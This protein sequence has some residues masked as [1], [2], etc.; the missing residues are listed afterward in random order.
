MGARLGALSTY[1]EQALPVLASL[2][3]LS[4][5]VLIQP[6]SAQS[7]P[8]A[9]EPSGSQ[10]NQRP[11]Q[12]LRPESRWFSP[13][14][15]VRS[16]GPAIAPPEYIVNEPGDYLNPYRQHPL[17][18]DFPLFG[19]E[20][21]F[22]SVTA[23]ERLIVEQRNVPTPTLITG[24]GPVRPGFFGNGRQRVLNSDLSVTFD[25]F[26]GQQA[27]KPVDWR[28]KFTPVWNVNYL[29]V[30]E[31]GVV[32][33][34]TNKGK[35]RTTQD[36]SLQEAFVEYHIGDLSDR[37]DFFSIE[38][39]ILPFRSDFR[40]FIF[41]DVNLGVR[42]FGNYDQNKWQYNL[43]VFDTL[44][45]NSNSLLNE[46]KDREQFVAIANIYRQDWPVLGYTSS[47]S[48][49]YNKDER[50]GLDFDNNGFL[51][52]PAPIGTFTNN[53]IEAYYLGWA[54]EG[55]FGRW[56]I[57]HAIYQVFG[58]ETANALAGRSVDI[59]AQFA[60]V[61][62]SYD[63]DWW[64]PRVFGLYASGDNDTRD[65]DANGFDAIF[66][67]PNFAGGDFSF[68][69]R[70]GLRL[71][72]T[73]LTNPQSPLVDLQTSK[74]EGQSNFVNPGVILLGGAADFEWTPKFRMQA[75]ASYL[76][77]VQT[78]VLEDFLQT[79]N[80]DRG[81][82]VDLFVGAQY[83]PWLNNEVIF[84]FG[85]NVLLPDGGFARIYESDETLYSVFGTAII[86][87]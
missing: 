49:H 76:Q 70:Q 8:G 32:N 23:T 73:G 82:G 67:A 83:R 51:V 12:F 69:N 66:D 24:S 55:H 20:D 19:T 72:G 37:Y 40:G 75:G 77:F 41:D 53:E 30:E 81:I 45:K 47:L 4:S 59:N 38:A 84:Q 39:G 10:S 44:N 16:S 7:S 17:K 74:T 46:F 87:W 9:A 18:G 54:G 3:L 86:S 62:V 15:P 29:E 22:L 1:R 26:K 60:A 48:F 65:G 25:L 50:S 5:A 71:L 31:V 80:I 21:L 43:A 35:T 64:R 78:D 36:I 58:E 14:W 6:L 61:E 42:V 68:W 52:S 13:G 56:N 2:S 85:G 28:I 33:I 34:N 79:P 27:F 63:I 57:T 11:Q